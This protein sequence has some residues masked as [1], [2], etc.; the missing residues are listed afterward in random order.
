M[1]V[2]KGVSVC[3]FV[4]RFICVC[5]FKDAHEQRDVHKRETTRRVTIREKDPERERVM[6]SFAVH[7]DLLDFGSVLV[8][9]VACVSERA[10]GKN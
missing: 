6:V 2:F 1:S 9:R 10:R 3:V 4:A 7:H 8:W 5:V